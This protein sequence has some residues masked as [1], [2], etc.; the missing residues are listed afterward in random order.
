MLSSDRPRL[1]SWIGFD[2][3]L[4]RST[5][6]RQPIHAEKRCMGQGLGQAQRKPS[7]AAPERTGDVSQWPD[8][9]QLKSLSAPWPGKI[10]SDAEPGVRLRKGGQLDDRRRLPSGK[11]ITQAA[12]PL[13]PSRKLVQLIIEYHLVCR[14]GRLQAA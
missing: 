13:D 3:N 14:E 8:L 9:S 10:E 6:I 11:V 12:H 2:A 7:L 4:N 1:K 5:A